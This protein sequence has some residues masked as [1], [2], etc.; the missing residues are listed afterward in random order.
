MTHVSY[1]MMTS[2]MSTLYLL[3]LYYW[4]ESYFFVHIMIL[5]IVCY[6]I[7]LN[8]FIKNLFCFLSSVKFLYWV[9][10][11]IQTIWTVPPR[12]SY[13]TWK[14]SSS[15]KKLGT[16]LAHDYCYKAPPCTPFIRVDFDLISGNY[17]TVENFK[18]VIL[19]PV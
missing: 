11:T 2:Q 8:N 13:Q 5:Q 4:I 17:V 3:Y 9:I 14:K 7:N 1:Y 19:V 10:E 18:V 15:L 6:I 12:L 16:F